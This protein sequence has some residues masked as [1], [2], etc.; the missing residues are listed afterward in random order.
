MRSKIADKILSET[1]DDVREKVRE[2][3]DK[4]VKDYKT[5]NKVKLSKSKVFHKGSD[6]T[7]VYRWIDDNISHGLLTDS[8]KSKYTVII[9]THEE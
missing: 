4:M 3:G 5:K 8:I 6:I 7:N 1:P 9:Q 2:I